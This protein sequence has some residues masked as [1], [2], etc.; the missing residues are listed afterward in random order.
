MTRSITRQILKFLALC[1]VP[2]LVLANLS[3]PAVA[4]PNCDRNPDH[5]KCGGGEPPPSGP[6]NPKVAY[7][8]DGGIYL[9]NADG[10]NRTLIRAGSDVKHPALYATPTGGK[11]LFAIGPLGFLNFLNYVPYEV[12][13][14]AIEP[15]QEVTLMTNVQLDAA[16]PGGSGM[17]TFGLMDWSPDGAR[18]AYSF[19]QQTPDGAIYRI[20]VSPTLTS[21]FEDHVI[22]RQGAPDG[23]QNEA[24]WDASG[25]FIY[26]TEDDN[27]SP[28]HDLLVIDVANNPGQVLAV[29]NIDNNLIAAGGNPAWNGN[30]EDAGAITGGV[31]NPANCTPDTCYSF[32]TGIAPRGDTSLCLL[33]RFTDWDSRNN[34]QYSIILDLPSIFDAN[35]QVSC[36]VATP[37]GGAI[38]RFE[39]AEFTDNDE[40]L[41]GRD[42]G[43]KRRQNSGVWTYD[44]RPATFGTSTRL[45]AD[46]AHPDWAN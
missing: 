2:V 4:A 7:V 45:D 23:G 24:Q 34:D 21:P 30:S 12:I 27:D 29:H 14:G 42:Q 28:S 5:P 39:A 11:V 15:G 26:Y 3:G 22:V 6:A 8:K 25:D 44:L 9:A 1:L 41:V 17:T 35:A 33:T 10:S 31:A 13:D 20:M 46:G 19:H 18:Y 38:Q 37:P 32:G 16:F 43:G 40:G 36:P